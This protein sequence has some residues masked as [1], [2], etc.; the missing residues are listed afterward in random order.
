MP[1]C[2]NAC[3]RQWTFLATTAL[4]N[5]E[6]GHALGARVGVHPVDHPHRVV[7][8]ALNAKVV[9][10]VVGEVVLAVDTKAGGTGTLGQSGRVRTGQTDGRDRAVDNIQALEAGGG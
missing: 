2:L 3:R 6:V 8:I 1:Q 5:P 10:A 9:L 7:A 4:L